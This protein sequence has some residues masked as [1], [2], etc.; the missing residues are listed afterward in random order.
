MCVRGMC[1]RGMCVCSTCLCTIVLFSRPRGIKCGK[2]KKEAR[3]VFLMFLCPVNLKKLLPPKCAHNMCVHVF[4]RSRVRPCLQPCVQPVRAGRPVF[5]PACLHLKNPHVF[6]TYARYIRHI[7]ALYTAHLRA[8][9]QTH[10]PH[11][12]THTRAQYS[13]LLLIKTSSI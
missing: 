12:G 9:Y 8:I 10:T 1:V 7:Y 11:V 3:V 2:K 6:S 4:L 5:L 13:L